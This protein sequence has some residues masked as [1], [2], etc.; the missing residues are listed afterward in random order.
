MQMF[1]WKLMSWPRSAKSVCASSPVATQNSASTSATIRVWNP[2]SI[3][4]PPP[5]SMAT[6]PK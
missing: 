3:S 5:S 6:T 1:F 4:K 2:S